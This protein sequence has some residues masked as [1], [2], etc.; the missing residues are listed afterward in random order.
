MTVA[1]IALTWLLA[2]C[3]TGWCLRRHYGENR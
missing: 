2:G 1:A 3:L